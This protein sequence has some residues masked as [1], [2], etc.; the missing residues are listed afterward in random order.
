MSALYAH[1]ARE[2]KTKYSYERIIGRSAA[3]REL[4]FLLDRVTDSDVPVYLRGESGVGKELAARAIHYNG[5]RAKAPFVTENCAAIPEALFESE[6]FGYLKGAFTGASA[7]KKGLFSLAD[8]GTLFLDEVAELPAAVQAKLLRVLQEG[9]VRPVGGR[10]PVKVD[11]RLLTASNKDLARAVERGS[12]RADLFHRIHVIEV[13][14]PA[15]RRRLEDL[16]LLVEHFLARLAG[17]GPPAPSPLP[18][19][20]SSPATPGRGMCASW[21]TRSAGPTP[22]AT[23]RSGPRRSPRPCGGRKARF[24]GDSP[25][26]TSAPRSGRRRGK[27]SG[28]SSRRR[29]GSKRGTR[30]RPPAGWELPVPPWMPRW[31]GLRSRDTRPRTG[32][33][34]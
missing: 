25:P 11:V 30:A 20:T 8:G 21:K 12:F 34:R 18:P 33:S 9:E 32:G 17:E 19:S 3:M 31:R 2:E 7:D 29:F 13:E 6:L 5:P 23:G 16:P 28:N 15:L 22:S 4:F 26:M 14:V 24:P 1:A 27:W 10:S